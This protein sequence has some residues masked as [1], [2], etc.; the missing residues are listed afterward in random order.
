MTIDPAMAKKPTR[1]EIRVPYKT[2]LKMSRPVSSVPNQCSAE[3]GCKQILAPF[4]VIVWGDK[5][6]EQATSRKNRT[7]TPPITA[8]R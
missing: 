8:D 7:I 2:R 4:R 6:G 1:R 3:G 5:I